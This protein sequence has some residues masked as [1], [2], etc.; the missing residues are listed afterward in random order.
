[1][2]PVCTHS[3]PAR[4]WGVL[5]ELAPALT[6]L[7]PAGQAT[8]L[9]RMFEQDVNRNRWRDVARQSLRLGGAVWQAWLERRLG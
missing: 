4:Q 9:V 2:L 7:L 5:E 6:R 3:D 1:V 8:S